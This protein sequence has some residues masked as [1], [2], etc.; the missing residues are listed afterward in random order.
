M[1]QMLTRF[2][3]LI[4]RYSSGVSLFEQV[5]HECGVPLMQFR[6]FFSLSI[7]ASV[8]LASYCLAGLEERRSKGVLLRNDH[9]KVSLTAPSCG[10]LSCPP[11]TKCSLQ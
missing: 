9:H 3:F 1:R 8:Q 4:V 2:V 7:T 5:V 10:A 6:M 11:G